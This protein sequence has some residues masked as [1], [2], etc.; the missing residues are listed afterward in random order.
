MTQYVKYI[1]GNTQ[2]GGDLA[3]NFLL[4]VDDGA[5]Q[6]GIF[7]DT[8]EEAEK[9]ISA[10]AYLR[11]NTNEAVIAKVTA[12]VVKTFKKENGKCDQ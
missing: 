11:H 9:Q 4:D 1:V 3:E 12:E 8:V 5:S 10:D 6:P 7:F 2:N